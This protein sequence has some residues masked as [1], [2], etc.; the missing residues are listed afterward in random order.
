MLLCVLLTAGCKS[1]PRYDLIEAELRTRERELAAAK[2]EL[3]NSRQLN[4]AYQRQSR[5]PVTGEDCV[6]GAFQPLKELILG[7]GT[8]GAD[9]D[10]Q[11][12]DEALQVV[13]V[14][15]D[16]DNS[17]VKVPA[18]VTVLAYEVSR[19]GTKTAIG[20]WDVSADQLHKTW[21]SGLFATGY[22][23]LLQWDQLPATEKVRL[24]VQM[25]TLDGRAFEADKDITVRVL[26]GV[27]PGNRD[28][29]PPVFGPQPGPLPPTGGPTPWIPAPAVP[30][31]PSVPPPIAPPMIDELPPPAEN[32]SQRP[33][34]LA[35]A[36]PRG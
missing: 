16:E 19:S 34:T 28:P 1:S 26:P 22:Y 20:R 11:P 18:T 23:V 7:S 30:T 35:P 13:L 15:R 6:G 4:E 8:G 25:K 14:P 12:G 21:R 9:N 5:G 10:G 29:G 3:R 2:S 32:R 24:V 17:A 36:R 27:A 31:A 33:V